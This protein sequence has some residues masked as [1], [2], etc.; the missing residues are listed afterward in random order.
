M[1]SGAIK[2]AASNNATLTLASPGTSGSLGDNKAIVVDTTVPTIAITSSTINVSDGSITNDST[3]SLTFTTSESTSNFTAGDVTVTNG[4]IS[5][6]A[7]SGTSY[8]ATFTP[9]AAGACTIDVAKDKFTDAASNNNTASIQFNWTYDNVG[10]TII[11]SST[12]AGV[13]D[14]SSSNDTRP[15]L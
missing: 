6:F 3:I 10:P 9:T 4:S 8:T 13:T 14:G 12:T 5:S 1:N 15:L 7:G 11:I 2:D